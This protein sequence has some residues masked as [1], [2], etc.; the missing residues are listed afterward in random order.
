MQHTQTKP[1]TIIEINVNSL[2]SKKHR[3]E[4]ESFT[5]VHRPDIV[6]VVETVI[7]D[8][9]NVT[10]ANYD[11]VR[12]DK[13]AN[14][15]E[16]G[17]G[18][19]VKSTIVHQPVDTKS[20]N[21]QSLETTAVIVSSNTQKLL[22]VSAYRS[23]N[24]A[25]LLAADLDKIAD[26]FC[27]SGAT[28][29]IIGGDF[30]ALHEDWKN[31]NHNASGLALVQWMAQNTTLQDFKLLN[32][33]EPTFYR[34][35]YTSYLDL[36][37]V[38]G[39]VDVIF[40]PGHTNELAI[41]DYPSDHRAI[42]LL[43]NMDNHLVQAVP[44]TI[45]NYNA[46]NWRLFNDKLESNLRGQTI[47][48]HHNMTPN[49]I[50][51]A[52]EM[53]SCTIRNTITQIVPT[54]VIRRNNQIILPQD[55]TILINNRKRLRRR[56]Q[57]NRYNHFDYQ[58]R[59]EIKCLTTIIDERIKDY[60]TRHWEKTLQS[61]KLNHNT[62]KKIKQ[63]TGAFRRSAIPSINDPITGSLLTRDQDKADALGY[64]FEEV[65]QRNKDIGC[66][67]HTQQ[68][69]SEVSM[70]HKNVHSPKVIFSR[71]ASAN[72]SFTHDAARHIVSI[73]SLNEI[74]KSRANKKSVGAD[75]IPNTVLKRLS[76][77]AKIFIAMLLN[78]IFNSGYYPR[79]WKHAIVIPI[80]KKGKPKEIPNSYRP[81]ALLPC[82]GKIYE[83]AV[84][85]RL[86]E[87]CIDLKIIPDDQ[88]GF[89][90][91]RNPSQPQVKFQTDIATNLNKR[92]PT[93]ACALDIEKAFDSLWQEGLIHKMKLFNI[94]EHVCRVVYNYLKERTFVVKINDSISKNFQI[95]AGVPQGGVLSANLYNIFLADLPMPPPH[96][97]QIQRL[98]YA[99]D[100]LVYVSTLNLQDGQNRL[101]S[102][103]SELLTFY[104]KWKI[105]LNPGKAEAIVFKDGNRYHSRGVNRNHNNVKVMVN[106]TQVNL[107]SSIRY[108][109]VIFSKKLTFTNHV[110]YALNKANNSFQSIRPILNKLRGL[111]TRLKLLCYK[112][113]IRPVAAYGFT[114]W[115][116]ISSHQMERLRIFERKCLRAATDFRR[117]RGSYLQISNAKLYENANIERI[118]THL[119]NTAVRVFDNWPNARILADCIDLD[120]QQLEDPLTR[121]KPAWFIHHLNATD[122]LFQ[123]NTPVYFHRRH[124]QTTGNTDH[125]YNMSA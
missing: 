68:I 82:L 53:L 86:R 95:A 20:W 63:L 29:L 15:P 72:P 11:F 44:K 27:N 24:R 81:I 64:H 51:E 107:L 103:L 119:S 55:I 18:I 25:T 13:T 121:H 10:F 5:G 106:G 93:I 48:N 47:P 2:I 89:E 108:L 31:T 65:H 28:H 87:E 94:S 7:S 120:G 112:Q 97:R 116:H 19:L 111:S 16:R 4:L 34:G 36:F 84:Q 79:S 40:M 17:T 61:V 14:A 26:H 37:L 80:H 75:G 117:E 71:D 70:A 32:T 91:G 23:P 105:K 57:R 125:V 12:S 38:C 122:K 76:S 60:H 123:G 109:G 74:L 8:A 104:E 78:Q 114:A 41:L 46:T 3:F 101:N 88:F 92:T 30:N 83:C 110:T 102:Y 69:N 113:L 52:V 118:D 98:Q 99:D 22:L 124:N 21:L 62:F 59:S 77:K 115:C 66:V 73:N 54:T 56:W 1:L 100:T 67:I 85:R 58:L 39:D 6:M 43:V 33:K 50:D 35:T 9:H 45:L 49:D 96:P 42:Q 90:H